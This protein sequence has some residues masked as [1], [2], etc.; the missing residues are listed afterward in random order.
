M[1][2]VNASAPLFMWHNPLPMMDDCQIVFF[3]NPPAGFPSSIQY[4]KKVLEVC[5]KEELPRIKQQL[6]AHNYSFWLTWYDQKSVSHILSR[7]VKP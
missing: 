3:T 7:G 2:E 4:T 5:L 6:A 1:L